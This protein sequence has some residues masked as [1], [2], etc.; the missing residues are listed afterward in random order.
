[1]RIMTVVCYRLNKEATEK[2]TAC[3]VQ[4]RKLLEHFLKEYTNTK[5]SAVGSVI[6]VFQFEILALNKRKQAQDLQKL[7]KKKQ[8]PNNQDSQFKNVIKLVFNVDSSVCLKI[9]NTQA[10]DQFADLK[11]AYIID[12]MEHKL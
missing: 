4:I 8:R 1:M 2:L 11:V 9:D 5:I 10:S 7:C 3:N 6:L 12:N